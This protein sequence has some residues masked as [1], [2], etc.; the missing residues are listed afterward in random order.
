MSARRR[1]D[2]LRKA[3]DGLDQGDQPFCDAFLG[4]NEVTLDECYDL[5]EEM[6][7]GA[8]IMAWAMENPKDA[9]AFLASGSAGMALNAITEALSKISLDGG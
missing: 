7:S 3:A 6:A 8:R 4:A 1:A 9:A 5:A 2:L